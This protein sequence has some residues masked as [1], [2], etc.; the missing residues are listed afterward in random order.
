MAQVW[1]LYSK[2]VFFCTS[3]EDFQISWHIPYER[4]RLWCV[5][6]R[7]IKDAQDT[8]GRG[9]IKKKHP[10]LIIIRS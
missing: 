1:L 5:H 3:L 6:V 10:Y 7:D 8:S 4:K 2:K 9:Q